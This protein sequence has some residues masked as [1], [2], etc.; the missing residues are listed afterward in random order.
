MVGSYLVNTWPFATR[1]TG[2]WHEGITFCV[3]MSMYS[4]EIIVG[5]DSFIQ[6]NIAVSLKFET[7]YDIRKI[8]VMF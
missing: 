8:N 7:H 3:S 6:C 5:S 4:S 2:I 1:V